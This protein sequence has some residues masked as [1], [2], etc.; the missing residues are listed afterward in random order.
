MD[1]RS[2]EP[3]VFSARPCQRCKAG[4]R[5]PQNPAHPFLKQNESNPKYQYCPHQTCKYQQ[6]ANGFLNRVD[7]HFEPHSIG[8]GYDSLKH[9]RELSEVPVEHG[10]GWAQGVAVSTAISLRLLVFGSGSFE[11]EG[12]FAGA[13]LPCGD[14]GGEQRDNNHHG[15]DVMDA[16]IN[17]GHVRA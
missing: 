2:S 17:I 14:D 1:P 7:T 16:F 9:G 11:G 15:Q 5:T 10:S 4:F 12:G 3:P 13:G 8:L 6:H